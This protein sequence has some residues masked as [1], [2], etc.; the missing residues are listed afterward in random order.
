MEILGPLVVVRG[1]TTGEILNIIGLSVPFTTTRQKFEY[2]VIVF[3]MGG[4]DIDADVV[5]PTLAALLHLLHYHRFQLAVCQWLPLLET[6]VVRAEFGHLFHHIVAQLIATCKE[7]LNEADDPF[8]LV[9][10]RQRL[11]VVRL[12]IGRAEHLADDVEAELIETPVPMDARHAR[13]F[14]QAR[15]LT[16]ARQQYEAL[17]EVFRLVIEGLRQAGVILHLRTLAFVVIG[18]PDYASV[19]V[20]LRTLV[21]FQ[22]VTL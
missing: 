18:I 6:Q 17:F 15:L 13:L 19:V 21:G 20:G 3:D 12:L 10:L 4:L 11:A 5:H 9:H 14:L 22:H 1:Q 7:V 8:F 16:I 2:G